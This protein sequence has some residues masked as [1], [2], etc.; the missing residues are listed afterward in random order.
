MKW[1]TKKKYM[2]FLFIK[3]IG[4]FWSI[5]LGYFKLRIN[6]LFLKSVVYCWHDL[7]HLGPFLN[8]N[9]FQYKCSCCDRI[10]HSSDFSQYKLRGGAYTTT[11]TFQQKQGNY[12]S[13]CGQQL[14]TAKNHFRDHPIEYLQQ[15]VKRD[16][17]ERRGGPCGALVKKGPF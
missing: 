1:E 5:S 2:G 16:R 9:N 15:Q 7:D 10:F 6:L 4:K 17:R 14:D 12:G 11:Y 3:I 13:M 8:R